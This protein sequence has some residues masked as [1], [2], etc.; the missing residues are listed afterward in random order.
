VDNSYFVAIVTVPALNYG[1]WE[2]IIR[3]LP[4][5]IKHI[6]VFASAPALAVCDKPIGTYVQP[7][8][9][10]IAGHSGI[11]GIGIIGNT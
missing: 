2:M 3:R 5:W 8:N 1:T 11:Y 7:I 6:K 4:I 10:S 9:T